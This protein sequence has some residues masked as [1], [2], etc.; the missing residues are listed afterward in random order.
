MDNTIAATLASNGNCILKNESNLSSKKPKDYTAILT[1]F[2]IVNNLFAGTVVYIGV[3]QGKGSVYVQVSSHEMIRYL[4]L[5]SIQVYKGTKLD[6]G[7]FLGTVSSKVGLGFEY[8]SQWKGDSIY[9]V[10]NDNK[11]YYK[12]N[13]ID[14]LNGKYQPT[15]PI[16]IQPG[17]TL[18]KD[19]MEFTKAQLPEWELEFGEPDNA[20]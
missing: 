14:I 12:Q 15:A 11:L 5:Q 6:K 19:K 2:T 10:R 16:S 8:C 20:P 3:Y 9:P 17:I 13:P 4:N 1:G 7:A 18:L